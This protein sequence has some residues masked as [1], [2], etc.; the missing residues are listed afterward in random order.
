MNIKRLLFRSIYGLGGLV[1]AL[2]MTINRYGRDLENR[3]RFPRAII[4]DGVCLSQDTVLGESTRVHEGSIINHSRIGD[5]T[6]VY[7]NA[8]IQNTTIGNYCSISHE[9]ICGLG[10]HPLYMFSTSPLFYR[11]KNDFGIKV[12]D[13]N[14][15]FVEY[16]PIK[17]GNDVWIGARVT[18]MD[19]VS[20]GDGAVIAAGAVVTHDVPDYAVVGGVPAKVIRYRNS[21]ERT[22]S[23]KVTHWWEL[24]PDDAFQLFNKQIKENEHI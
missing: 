16:K 19:G 1:K 2:A 7:R 3:H 17:I 21:E 8:L 20:V 14:S 22:L 13:K 24:A 18:I 6:Y 10:A 12:V 4:S 23:Y 11:V 15:D 9:L 5:Y